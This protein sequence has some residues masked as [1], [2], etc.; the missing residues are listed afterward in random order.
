MI[1]QYQ[2]ISLPYSSPSAGQLIKFWLWVLCEHH[3]NFQCIRRYSN[4]DTSYYCK[5]DSRTAASWVAGTQRWNQRD[6]IEKCYVL[7]DIREV[8]CEWYLY[9]ST[10]VQLTSE[11]CE[12]GGITSLI[13]SSCTS[14]Q[15]N[16][17]CGQIISSTS[18][19][20]WARV[21]SCQP[22][23][24]LILTPYDWKQSQWSN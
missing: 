23:M 7:T 4:V 19:I 10:T 14:L 1:F 16:N 17:H 5:Y 20:S 9:D 15:E 2:P 22:K 24:R 8:W 12:Y 13:N 18:E 11:S 6:A 3:W 21:K